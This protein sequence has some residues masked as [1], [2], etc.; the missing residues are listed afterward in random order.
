MIEQSERMNFQKDL[1]LLEKMTK[2][3]DLFRLANARR[4]SLEQKPKQS[5]NFYWMLAAMCSCL[6]FIFL[7]SPIKFVQPIAI[8]SIIE[9][10]RPELS[11]N[12]EFAVTEDANFY[13]W[14]DIYDQ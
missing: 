10:D 8:E 9:I 7:L 12:Q 2:P 5:L 14:L 6:F 13:Y 11:Q 4:I 3:Q 1:E